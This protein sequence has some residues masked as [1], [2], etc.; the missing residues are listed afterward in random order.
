MGHNKTNTVSSVTPL[1]DVCLSAVYPLTRCPLACCIPPHKMSA[2]LYTP[3][4]DVHFAVYPLTRCP[5]C[6]I[7]P[8]KMSTFLRYTP[9]QDVHLSTVYPLTRC[10]LAC[11]IPPHKMSTLLYTPSQD[12]HFSAV[13][14]LTRCRT[15]CMSQHI[16]YKLAHLLQTVY[17]YAVSHS[18]DFQLSPC[19]SISTFTSW[20]TVCKSYHIVTSCT[21]VC[22]S[23]Y[24]TQDVQLSVCHTTLTRCPTVC[25][26]TLTQC[27]V[28]CM[29]Y[30]VVTSCTTVYV[31]PCSHKLY[32]CLYM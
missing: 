22:M 24:T 32:N 9:S 13:Y 3:S 1:Q 16:C 20:T 14:P 29:S 12:V 10:P 31:I 4:Q 19:H 30:H 18:E 15:V 27:P 7:P 5:L 23:Q 17:R 8:H 26:T 28:V 21:N 11:C 25:H 6:C 2:L